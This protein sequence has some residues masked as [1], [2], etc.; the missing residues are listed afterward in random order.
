MRT[1]PIKGMKCRFLF[2]SGQQALVK[3]FDV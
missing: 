2:S 3:R 1:H